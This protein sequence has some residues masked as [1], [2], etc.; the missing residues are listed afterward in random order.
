MQRRIAACG[1]PQASVWCTTEFVLTM[2]SPS[3]FPQF[4][5]GHRNTVLSRLHQVALDRASHACIPSKLCA[6]DEI[7]A[8]CH[9]SLALGLRKVRHVC[10]C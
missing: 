7:H 4:R 1:V 10:G 5:R 9:Q 6:A 2:V 3:T 8:L